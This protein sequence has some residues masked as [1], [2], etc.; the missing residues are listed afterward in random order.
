MDKGFNVDHTCG[1]QTH[2]EV[3]WTH[4]GTKR[5]PGRNQDGDLHVQCAEW[6]ARFLFSVQSLEKK[7]PQNKNN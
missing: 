3:K 5:H 2:E 1:M 4:R 6:R 7:E